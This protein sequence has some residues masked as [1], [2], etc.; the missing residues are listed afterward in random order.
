MI[1]QKNKWRIK[2]EELKNRILVVRDGVKEA[3]YLEDEMLLSDIKNNVEGAKDRVAKLIDA[4]FDGNWEYYKIFNENK[5]SY[6]KVH[7]KFERSRD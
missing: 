2:M 7:H 3:F 4:Y 6:I 5:F 1:H